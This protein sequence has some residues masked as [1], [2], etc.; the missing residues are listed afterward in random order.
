M[1]ESLDV[2]PKTTEQNLIVRIGK[3]SEVR[4]TN[5][6]RLRSRYYTVEANYWETR[7][8]VRLLCNSRAFSFTYRSAA[9]YRWWVFYHWP[10]CF[11][12]V[13]QLNL[14]VPTSNRQHMSYDDCL[15]GKLSELLCAVL[16]TMV[17]YWGTGC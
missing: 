2:T 16:C 6:K 7:S 3:K 14:D 1:T 5:N 11:L 13:M 4:V 9:S 12:N 15:E 10:K 8:I 17:M